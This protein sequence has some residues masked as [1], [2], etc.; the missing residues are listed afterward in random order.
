MYLLPILLRCLLAL[1]GV[2]VPADLRQV[3][4]RIAPPL[5]EPSRPG[6]PLPERVSGET[7]EVARNSPLPR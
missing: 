2:D 4:C 1:F 5:N 6:L 3:A 7:L